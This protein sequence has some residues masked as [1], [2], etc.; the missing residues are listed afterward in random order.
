LFI[1]KKQFLKKKKKKKNSPTHCPK[2]YYK[3]VKGIRIIYENEI[4]IKEARA[5]RR[6]LFWP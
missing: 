1:I 6:L 4:F 5:W 2:M 3:K